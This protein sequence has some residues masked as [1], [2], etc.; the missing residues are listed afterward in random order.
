M[1]VVYIIQSGPT[2]PVTLG[3]ATNKGL[4]RRL[5]SLQAG[6]PEILQLRDVFDGDERLERELHVRWTA[7]RI[8]GDW[9]APAV[10]QDLPD[11]PKLPHDADAEQRRQAAMVLAD[12]APRT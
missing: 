4:S 9:Y 5:S 6:N 11:R 2:G 12:L 3:T 7:H 1:N 8:R 10:L